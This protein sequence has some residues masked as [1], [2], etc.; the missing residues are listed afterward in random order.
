MYE[1]KDP[2]GARHTFEPAPVEVKI[3]PDDIVSVPHPE[4]KQ[5]E[6]RDFTEFE[7]IEPLL[8]GLGHMVKALSKIDTAVMSGT[9]VKLNANQVGALYRLL[10]PHVDI[11]RIEQAATNY[12]K[13]LTDEPYDHENP[14]F[15]P[16]AYAAYSPS[17]HLRHDQQDSTR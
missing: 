9:G 5:E 15:W 10:Q 14:A 3:N 12:Y 16:E 6:V 4:G 11:N 17:T 13:A 8:L 7:E 2:Y 1:V